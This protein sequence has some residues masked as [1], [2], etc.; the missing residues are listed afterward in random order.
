MTIDSL[1]QHSELAQAAYAGLA[2]GLTSAQKN[3]FETL[4]SKEDL[5]ENHA[6]F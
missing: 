5:G 4:D 6:D 3:N 2:R 1:Y